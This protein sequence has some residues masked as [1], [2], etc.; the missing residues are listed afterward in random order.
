MRGM[1][2]AFY[3]T[4]VVHACEAK[5]ENRAKKLVKTTSRAVLE[6]VIGGFDYE[7]TH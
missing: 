4:A 7:K 2:I 3:M 1:L 5:L 6:L